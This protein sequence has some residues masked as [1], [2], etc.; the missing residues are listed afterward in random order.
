MVLNNQNIKREVYEISKFYYNYQFEFIKMCN[1]NNSRYRLITKTHHEITSNR[2]RKFHGKDRVT[3]T[4]DSLTIYIVNV[5][6][7]N[8]NSV[9]GILLLLFSFVVAFTLV[10]CKKEVSCMQSGS[11]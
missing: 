5:N 2:F 7:N 1:E 4:A 10:E 3:S 9:K 8:M 6:K 11:Y